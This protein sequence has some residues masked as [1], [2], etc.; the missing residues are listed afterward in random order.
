MPN[1]MVGYS[2]PNNMAGYLSPQEWQAAQ[3]AAAAERF[4]QIQANQEIRKQQRVSIATERNMVFTICVMLLSV[5]FTETLTNSPGGI[6]ATLAFWLFELLLFRFFSKAESSHR[7][8]ALTLALPVMLISFSFS[9]FRDSKGYFL[10]YVTMLVLI[11]LQLIVLSG[12]AIKEVFSADTIFEY[13]RR[14]VLKPFENFDLFFVTLKPKRDSRSGKLK[15]LV[16]V[17]LGVLIAIPFVA[18][19]LSLFSSADPAFERGYLD[20]IRFI[21]IDIPVG[22]I[23]FDLFFG[24]L[25]ALF[26]GTAILYNSVETDKSIKQRKPLRLNN[27]IG[28]SFIAVLNIV[29]AAFAVYQVIYFFTNGAYSVIVASIGYAAYA[30]RGF[31]ELCWASGIVFAL[32]ATVLALCKKEDKNPIYIRISILLTSLFNIIIAVSAV[33]RMLLYIEA[34]GFSVK[35]LSTFFGILV[36]MVSLVWLIAK[37][38]SPKFKSLKMIGVSIV[39]LVTL[40]SF[41]N[42]DRIVSGY[43]TPR[44]ISGELSPDLEYYNQLSYTCAGDLAILYND[45]KTNPLSKLYSIEDSLKD[46]IDWKRIEFE[47]R[48]L[49]CFTLDDIRVSKAFNSIIG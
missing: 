17:L 36:I 49:L 27:I 39:I 23:I 24:F 4:R 5:F 21:K 9:L 35:R 6:G 15:N 42:L 7:K 8:K 16:F 11:G 18:L 19:L 12:V 28:M 13:L 37:C 33:R 25:L 47:E 31:F 14:T 34:H 41:V 1:P 30:R 2:V 29:I 32:S 48:S 40:F 43:N 10:P 26:I 38:I 20:F 45:L 22:R 3:N 46:S 44:Y